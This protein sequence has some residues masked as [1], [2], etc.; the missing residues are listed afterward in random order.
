MV[1][2]HFLKGNHINTYHHHYHH[3][4]EKEIQHYIN[5]EAGKSALTKLTMFEGTNSIQ[6]NNRVDNRALL[7]KASATE[8]LHRITLSNSMRERPTPKRTNNQHSIL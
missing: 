8:S 6:T 2:E 1:F 5:Q 3:H 7:V 4:F